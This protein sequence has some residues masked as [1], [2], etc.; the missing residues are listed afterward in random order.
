MKEE[1]TKIKSLQE[2][3]DLCD[4]ETIEC[5]VQ[6]NYGARSWKVISFDGEDIWWVFNEIDDTEEE[7]TTKELMNS[8][9]G[10]ALQKGQLYYAWT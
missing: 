10:E 8:I 7:L 9:V 2:L 4:E 5:F 1:M 3:I 6:L